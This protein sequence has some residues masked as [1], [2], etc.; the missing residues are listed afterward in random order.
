MFNK[1]LRLLTKSKKQ[2]RPLEAMV[3]KL[4]DTNGAMTD[5]IAENNLKVQELQNETLLL[6]EQRKANHGII[7]NLNN[8]I[9][10]GC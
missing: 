3:N 8:I 7:N 9:K 4:I 2:V 6:Q 10:G 1:T 5:K